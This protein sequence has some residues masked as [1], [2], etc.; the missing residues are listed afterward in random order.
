MEVLRRK[1]PD[2]VVPSHSALLPES[3]LPVLED[4]D[5]NGGHVLSVARTI[6]GGA[7][8]G[9]CDSTHWQ[10]ALLR[11]GPSSERLRDSVAAL[12][13]QL[14]NTIVPW[15]HVWALM[16]NRLIALDKCP[17]V[18]PVGIGEA[19]RRVLGRTVCMVT[20]SDLEDVAG[21]DQLCAGTIMGIE[22]AI[23]LLEIYLMSTNREDGVFCWLMHIMLS[24][25]STALQHYGM[26]VPCGL[27]VAVSYSIHT[28]GGQHW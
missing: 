25:Q 28:V 7:G 21:I 6:Q 18:R 20:R 22:G 1:H 8:P 2:P 11:F 3:T 23:T 10:D 15:V 17:G 13:R 24:T 27:V 12:G 5:I 16:A 26:C 9:G 14:A 4:L 19:L